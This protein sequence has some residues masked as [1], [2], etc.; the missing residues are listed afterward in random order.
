MTGLRVSSKVRVTR[1]VTLD[2]Q[3]VVRKLGQL[4]A[5]QTRQ[6]NAKM[7]EAFQLLPT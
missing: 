7:I 3:L 4:S 6:L 2:R 5:Q 1:V